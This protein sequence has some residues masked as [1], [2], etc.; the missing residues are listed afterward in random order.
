M[1]RFITLSDVRMYVCLHYIAHLIGMWYHLI[2]VCSSRTHFPKVHFARYPDRNSFC[3][4]YT[5]DVYTILLSVIRAKFIPIVPTTCLFHLVCLLRSHLIWV[6]L[7]RAHF[8]WVSLLRAHYSWVSLLRARFIGVSLL[9]FQFIWVSL[10]RTQF[11]RV[12]TTCPLH[13]VVLYL[14]GSIH[15]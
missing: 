11:I 15:V 3:Q 2:P 13:V 4:G 10:L 7:L 8:I 12:P 5:A 14:A 1:T 6:S 9:R